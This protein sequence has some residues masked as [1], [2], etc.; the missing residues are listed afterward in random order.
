MT[1]SDTM[2]GM[3]PR[4]AVLT[5]L[6]VLPL[7]ILSGCGIGRS[8]DEPTVSATPHYEEITDEDLY[9]QIQALEKVV[10]TGIL[11]RTDPTHGNSYAGHILLEAGVTRGEALAILDH[12][13]AI[14]RQGS[15]RAAINLTA[16]TAP[17]TEPMVTVSGTQ[18]PLSGSGPA[19]LEK[20]YGP[21]PG[22]GT[23][24]GDLSP[25]GE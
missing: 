15:Y 12:A 20:R 8:R 25:A 11:H 2:N 7:G 21:Q 1:T 13:Y 6:S 10:D 14:L 18:L 3:L 4:R 9:A 22:D 5:M 16:A 17:D 24:P 23:P 19:G